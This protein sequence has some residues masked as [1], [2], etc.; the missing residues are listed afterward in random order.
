[1]LQRDLGGLHLFVKD[2]LVLTVP[3]LLLFLFALPLGLVA[4]QLV[5]RLVVQLLWQERLQGKTEIK[6]KQE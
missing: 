4:V 2:L 1:V 6:V 3:L 5:L